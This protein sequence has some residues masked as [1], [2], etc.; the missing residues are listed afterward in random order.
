M[1][2]RKEKKKLFPLERRRRYHIAIID[3]G[4]TGNG[5]SGIIFYDFFLVS[6]LFRSVIPIEPESIKSRT[7]I[8][9]GWKMCNRFTEKRI[10]SH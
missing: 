5:I 9:G 1:K 7:M 2:E 10:Y 8:V 6:P 3:D 4:R